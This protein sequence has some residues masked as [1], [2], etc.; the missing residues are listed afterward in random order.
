MEESRVLLTDG[1]LPNEAC[2]E[3]GLKSGRAL[4]I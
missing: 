4:C 1:I 3:Q 2:I